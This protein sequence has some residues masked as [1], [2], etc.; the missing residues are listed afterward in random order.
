MWRFP[1]AA[2]L[3]GLVARSLS[4]EGGAESPF[5]LSF[6]AGDSAWYGLRAPLAVELYVKVDC[7]PELEQ[8]PY[9][10]LGENGDCTAIREAP[11]WPPFRV[12]QTSPEGALTLFLED[13][14]LRQR[15]YDLF[16]EATLP[17]AGRVLEYYSVRVL[18][19]AVP[20]DAASY[21]DA[22]VLEEASVNLG[23][24]GLGVTMLSRPA[25]AV[26]SIRF[27]QPSGPTV[28]AKSDVTFVAAVAGSVTPFSG[29]K[30]LV[31]FPSPMIYPDEG[32][33]F[34]NACDLF[35]TAGFGFPLADVSCEV[36]AWP[37]GVEGPGV[38][39][40]NALRLRFGSLATLAGSEQYFRVSL[41]TTAKGSTCSAYSSRALNVIQFFLLQISRTVSLNVIQIFYYRS[42][43]THCLFFP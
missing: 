29:G 6:T 17:P 10:F 4:A 40:R 27:V 38:F 2:G 26:T 24:L 20:G 11:D 32:I 41:Q 16:V 15:K 36:L 22:S 28:A 34:D 9:V 14:V 1:V 21:L 30:E 42:R 3:R 19:G 35:S 12:C 43:R 39:G 37:D 33:G 18:Y 23:Y 13:A 7:R 31:L 5:L 8:C 25:A